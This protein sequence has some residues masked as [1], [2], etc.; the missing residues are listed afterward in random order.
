MRR[1]WSPFRLTSDDRISPLLAF[2]L[3]GAYIAVTLYVGLHHEPWRDEADAWLLV[4]DAPLAYIF[5]WTHN[6]GTPA[7]WYLL[8]KPLVWLGLPYVSLTILNL[9][10]AWAAAAVLLFEAPLT[11]LTKLLLLA[12][13]FL[14][15]EYAVIARSYSVTILLLFAALAMFP[16]RALP[17]AIAVALLFNTNIHGAIIAAGLLLVFLVSGPRAVTP[18]AV[19]V[20]GALLALLQVRPWE[21][22]ANPEAMRTV[23][24]YAGPVSLGDA[25]LP[26]SPW[27]AIAGPVVI[28]AVAL[29]IRRRKVALLF[30]I[31]CVVALLAVY[32]FIW[33]G[34]LRHSGLLLISLVASIWIARD[35]PLTPT[36][37]TAALLLNLT[38]VGSAAYAFATAT[39]DVRFAFSGSREM[40]EYIDHRFDDYDIA[41]HN[42]YAAEAL[43]PYL[44]GRR[45]WYAGLGEYGTYLRWDRK[46][47]VAVRMRYEVAVERARQHFAG[48]KWLFLVD[49]PMPHPEQHGFRLVHATGVIVFRHLDERYWLYAPL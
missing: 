49:S 45:F 1:E 48:R 34:G 17:F 10:I 13:Y 8:L 39:S 24:L 22:A 41:A 37:R 6:A 38:L 18:L 33:F 4:R 35:V 5:Q 43:L 2:S 3:L 28:V 11:S 19:M 23:R 15:Y 31:F 40:A 30:L 29:A 26:D 42:L 47:G 46:Q 12:S 7:L 32:V 9:L 25:F 36:T 16:K 14:A 20:A 21:A 27:G 44:P